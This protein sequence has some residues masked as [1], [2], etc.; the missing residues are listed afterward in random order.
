MFVSDDGTCTVTVDELTDGGIE[1]SFT[2]DAGYGSQP[3]T[4]DGPFEAS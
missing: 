3:L 2:C 4:A 1:G